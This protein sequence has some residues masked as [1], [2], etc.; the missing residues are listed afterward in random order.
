L[1]QGKNN[2]LTNAVAAICDNGRVMSLRFQPEKIA[3][4][5]LLNL[6]VFY[7]S[8]TPEGFKAR[9]RGLGCRICC[10][11]VSSQACHGC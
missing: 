7:L 2:Y 11:F 8:K 5:M 6:H 9:S 3:F 1:W 10:L 4:E